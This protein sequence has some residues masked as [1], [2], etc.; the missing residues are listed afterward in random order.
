MERKIIFNNFRNLGIEKPQELM[1]NKTENG[2]SL[3][4]LVIVIGGNNSGKTNVLNGVLTLEEGID[5]KLDKPDFIYEKDTDTYVKIQL[6]TGENKW[7]YIVRPNC[8]N[9]YDDLNGESKELTISK[10]RKTTPVY[11]ISNEMRTRLMQTGR[12][13][14][15]QK[16]EQLQP[17]DDAEIQNTDNA[18]GLRYNYGNENLNGKLR[19]EFDNYIVAM[20]IIVA[21]KTNSEKIGEINEQVLSSTGIPLIPKIINYEENFI[22]QNEM[23]VSI[24]DLDKSL[25]FKNIFY[26]MEINIEEVENCYKQFKT[27]NVRAILTQLQIKMNKKLGGFANL[28]NKMYSFDNN[29]YRFEFAFDPDKIYFS[30]I[31]GNETP[32]NLDRQSTGFRWFFNFF[33]YLSNKQDLKKGDIVIM[34]EPATNLHVRG[35]TELRDFLKEYA[36]RS[37]ITFIVS[38]HSPFMIDIDHLDELRIVKKDAEKSEIVNDFT[39]TDEEN[40]DALFDVLGSLT[41]GRHILLN[42]NDT[43]IFVEGITDYNYLVAFKN[44]FKK[45][46]IS[47][48]PVKGLKDKKLIEKLCEIKK[49]PI[50]LVD[51]DKAGEIAIEK[52]KKKGNKVE[53]HSL[54]DIDEKFNTIEDLFT[55]KDKDLVAGP[56]KT[57]K[58][59][60]Y[61]KNNY[62]EFIKKLSPETINN[63]KKL[64]ELLE[65]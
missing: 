45:P 3:G 7:S 10:I 41:V 42:P 46:N 33:I 32:L 27:S 20:K 9:A 23:V 61:I 51:G 26:I 64:L 8:A 17:L 53:I 37:G 62:A 31:Y 22:S 30:I 65:I 39:L 2:Q 36:H 44:Y 59:S 16:M 49:D 5:E 55:G 15:M 11:E 63:F 58:N 4:E 24:D 28:F 54:K 13:D 50:L 34:D 35:V 6:R 43:L 14:I 21:K 29:K 52:N 19:K 47:F 18:L 25:F 40:R 60:R 48:L 1:L 56:K 38:T 12:T 57:N